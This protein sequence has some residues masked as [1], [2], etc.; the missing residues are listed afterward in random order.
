MNPYTPPEQPSPGG[1]NPGVGWLRFLVWMMPSMLMVLLAVFVGSMA[2]RSSGFVEVG[3]AV[4][5][6]ACIPAIFALGHFDSK[7]KRQ[8]Q[9]L[10]QEGRVDHSGHMVK[11]FLLQFIV[12][13]AV[14]GV[15]A[16]GFCAL[17]L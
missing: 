11:F 12:V 16:F 3:A 14:T 2:G 4:Y 6:L 13:P 8:Q 1:R 5:F 9:G 10:S 15:I 17:A 7:L